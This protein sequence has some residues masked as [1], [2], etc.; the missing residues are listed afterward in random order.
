MVLGLLF[1]SHDWTAHPMWL[2]RGGM[3]LPLLLLLL[4]PLALDG[5]SQTSNVLQVSDILSHKLTSR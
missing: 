2:Q 3:T 1:L 5:H 4:L